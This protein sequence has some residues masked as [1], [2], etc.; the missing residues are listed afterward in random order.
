MYQHWNNW[1]VN[2][3]VLSLSFF[4]NECP[5][6]LL[7]TH[8]YKWPEVHSLCGLL[9][10]REPGSYLDQVPLSTMASSHF[11]ALCVGLTRSSKAAMHSEDALAS[12]LFSYRIRALCNWKVFAVCPG[13][14]CV[15]LIILRRLWLYD[16]NMKTNGPWSLTLCAKG[17]E[18]WTL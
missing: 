17:R 15:L 14:L 2:I 10:C 8:L 11:T 1:S 5:H 9:H 12:I 7:V 18:R 6:Y 3:C 13:T 4:V 16:S